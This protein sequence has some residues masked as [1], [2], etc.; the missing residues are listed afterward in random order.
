MEKVYG[1]EAGVTAAARNAELY[2]KL[3]G[4]RWVAW[5]QGS[6]VMVTNYQ[7]TRLPIGP[8][9]AV[10]CTRRQQQEGRG[11]RNFVIGEKKCLIYLT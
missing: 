4:R 6:M 10:Q 7:I 5:A 2:A 8:I 11:A 3:D 1:R 9:T